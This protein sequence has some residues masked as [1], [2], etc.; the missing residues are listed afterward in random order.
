M[1]EVVGKGETNLTLGSLTLLFGDAT[2]SPTLGHGYFRNVAKADLPTASF[3][4]SPQS[5]LP[6]PT[7]GYNVTF[8][9]SASIPDGGTIDEYKWYFGASFPYDIIH[10][11]V[12]EAA[13]D[14][15]ISY[16]YTMRT[17]PGHVYNVTLTVKDSDG[18]VASAKDSFTVK[19]YD[20]GIVATNLNWTG[21]EAPENITV[22]DSVEINVTILN[23]GDYSSSSFDVSAYYQY[24][25]GPITLIGTQT[26][27]SVGVGLE[28]NATITWDTSSLTVTDVFYLVWA[29][30]TT[31]DYEYD[32][33][34]NEGDSKTYKVIPLGL[35][36]IS[37]IAS[38]PSVRLYENITISGVITPSLAG[39][40]VTIW[41]RNSSE[42]A[43]DNLTS[44][45]TDDS[46]Q[47]SYN[48]TTTAIGTFELRANWPGD[49][50]YIPAESNVIIVVVGKSSSSIS[51]T[52]S[53]SN[54]ALGE[55]TT[56]SGAITPARQGGNVTIQYRIGGGSWDNLTSVLT[57]GSGQY[58]YDWTTTAIGTFELRAS[59]P[60]DEE[61]LSAESSVITVVVGKMSSSITLLASSSTITIGDTATL[62][63][64]L[65]PAR[66]GEDIN[67]QYR[68][69]GGS[70]NDLASVVTD[71]SGEYSYE[72]TPTEQVGTFELMASWPGDAEYLSA[73][74]S[75]TVV[76]GKMSSSIS[77]TIS[78]TSITLGDHFTISGAITP[79]L[80]HK[81]VTV[82]Y[83]TEVADWMNLLSSFQ[84]D[85]NGQY[86]VV[87]SPTG[88]G[89]GVSTYEFKVTW[90]GD[91]T[92]EG[93]ES[94]VVAGTV[95]SQEPPDFTL[96]VVAVV[97]I[98]IVAAI[99]IYFLKFRK[100]S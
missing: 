64:S 88:V 80:A 41:Y 45:L 63:G 96:L 85:E 46:S 94:D 14:T 72:W 16:N 95:E 59:W 37:I 61:C 82:Y 21:P 68:I 6:D 98:I 67:I 15:T 87:W 7:E 13:P 97:V 36:T 32:T 91:A 65:T 3:T 2:I 100:K 44:V 34:D 1:V 9:A 25:A 10:E 74:S 5:P 53:P 31:V 78:P 76:V 99:I 66:Q 26:G 38:P 62:S 23:Q 18:V 8:D 56:V 89:G 48:W 90:D 49:E 92:T 40:T 47:Y 39:K 81:T 51:I 28:I 70:W 17:P 30:C 55:T 60:G 42:A 27:L 52:V 57:D 54:V 75:V 4:W 71:D 12:T 50:D 22:G 83:K 58:S 20:I 69:G 33:G 73:E 43:W 86:S 79:P 11:V 24:P 35:S 29:N 19:A 84:T 77:I 93:A